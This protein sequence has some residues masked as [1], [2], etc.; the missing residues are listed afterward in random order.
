MYT[1]IGAGLVGVLTAS[2]LPA[3]FAP[4][5]P[6]N[7]I[8]TEVSEAVIDGGELLVEEGL[9]DPE[10]EAAAVAE[11]IQEID[12]EPEIP[13]LTVYDSRYIEESY[14]GEFKNLD[15]ASASFLVPEICSAGSGSTLNCDLG[16]L[17]I[18]GS[19]LDGEGSRLSSKTEIEGDNIIVSADVAEKTVFPLSLSAYVSDVDSGI[20]VEEAIESMGEMVGGNIEEFSE[21]ELFEEELLLNEGVSSDAELNA[22]YEGGATSGDA[23]DG[24]IH[25]LAATH[26]PLLS[27]TRTL[28]TSQDLVVVPAAGS[29]PAKIGIPGSYKYGPLKY[30]PKA[31]HDYCTWSPN[32]YGAASFKG[33]C[34]RHDMSI[35]SI[36]KKSIS[37]NSKISQRSS[38][39]VRFKSHLRQNCTNAF[40]G[41]TYVMGFN[42]TNCYSRTSVY[43]SV[44]TSKTK[45]WNGK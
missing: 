18:V 24:A 37:L 38:A 3:D 39:D 7:I 34:A 21:A 12:A 1:A 6:A 14:V 5:V 30:S 22:G 40:W 2:L 26:S 28:S 19:V 32:A 13:L 31:L 43:Y 11:E 33:P 15:V 9:V 23:G 42:R 10:I 29:R 16:N 27:F 20:I 25:S 4:S 44:V 41:S 17:K 36:R 35:D 8:N 45:N